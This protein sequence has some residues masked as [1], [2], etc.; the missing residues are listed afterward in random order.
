MIKQNKHHSK[1]PEHT[2]SSNICLTGSIIDATLPAST[3][4]PRFVSL[5]TATGVSNFNAGDNVLYTVYKYKTI[6]SIQTFW[7]NGFL[8]DSI[9][10]PKHGNVISWQI[11]TDG[12]EDGIRVVRSIINTN[13]LA[14]KD[15]GGTGLFDYLDTFDAGDWVNFPPDNTPIITIPNGPLSLETSSKLFKTVIDG[16]TFYIPLYQ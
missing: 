13:D 3:Q 9:I 14:Y 7:V 8:Q 16:Q 10:V 15:F 11:S 5:I 12:I 1:P 2:P 6:N 4:P